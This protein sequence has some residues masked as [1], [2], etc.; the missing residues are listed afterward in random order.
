MRVLRLC[1]CSAVLSGMM[2]SANIV[3]A[4]ET[5]QPVAQKTETKKPVEIE[6]DTQL[7]WLRQEFMYRATG[8]VVITQ[9]DTIIRGDYAE[10][11][12]DGKIGPS[13]LTTMKVKGNVVM[14]N[15]DRVIR[16]DV[17]DYDATNEILVVTGENVSLTAPKMTATS[18]E[19]MEYHAKDNKAVLQGNAEVSQPGQ[20]IKA[21]KI[22]AFFDEKTDQLIRAQA[23]GSVLITKQAANGTDIAQSRQADYDVRSNSVEL[24]GDV[25]LTR[26]DNHMQGD[27]AVIDLATGYSTMKNTA[28]AGK[29]RVRA[30]F[31]TG[32]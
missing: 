3:Q 11:Y 28:G 12:Y 31:H 26:G 9:G 25:K 7:E 18:K 32:K 2:M 21:A 6:A 27:H 4:A 10:A 13:A 20:K 29:G 30:V 8:N 15:L 22:T 1:V 24:K 16:G 19:R 5:V 14:T 23:V 17:A